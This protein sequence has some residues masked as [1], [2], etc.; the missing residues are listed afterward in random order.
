MKASPDGYK[1]SR[2]G[3]MADSDADPNA[4]AYI[5]PTL[6]YAMSN[7]DNRGLQDCREFFNNAERY[8]NSI[9]SGKCEIKSLK[10]NNDQFVFTYRDLYDF[11]HKV[12]QWDQNVIVYRYRGIYFGVGDND[13][14]E[15][16]QKYRHW[17]CF[18]EFATF[19][20]DMEDMSD[21][22]TWI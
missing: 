12:D 15:Y 20:E 9:A 8:L 14:I 7:G 5:G 6:K 2:V 11:I 13:Q 22:S 4:V 21:H 16:K 3:I 10:P 17:Q 18:R 19:Y 1:M